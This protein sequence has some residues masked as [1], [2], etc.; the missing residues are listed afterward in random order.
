MANTI[1]FRQGVKS[2]L[3]VTGL[4]IGEPLYVTDDDM[5]YVAT[6]SS[7]ST[8]IGAEIDANPSLGTSHIKLATQG[9]I[10]DYVDSATIE[11]LDLKDSCDCAS[12]EDDL[13]C[14]SGMAFTVT[15]L[16]T[17]AL[18]DGVFS[19]KNTFRVD[20]LTSGDGT[21]Q[22]GDV[23]TY[24]GSSGTITVTAVAGDNDIT[25]D[26]SALS[27]ADNLQLTFTKPVGPGQYLTAGSNETI[28][29]DGVLLTLG[30]RVLMKDQAAAEENGI[31]EVTTLGATGSAALVLTRTD[32]FNIAAAQGNYKG[33]IQTNA[34]TMVGDGTIAAETGWA[35]SALGSSFAVGT[36]GNGDITWTQFNGTHSIT[37]GTGL[38]KVGN[39]LSV[40]DNGIGLDQMAGGTDGNLI[41]FDTSGDPAYVAT[42]TA[43][44]ILTSNGVGVAPT[45]QSPAASTDVD[46]NVTNLTAR[47]PQVTENVTIGDAVDVT[48][49]T[50]GPLTATGLVTANAG[51]TIPTTKNLTMVS[52]SDILVNTDKFT[53]AGTSGNTVIAGTAS[54]AGTATLAGAITLG[55]AGAGSALTLVDSAASTAG[56]DFS[57]KGSDVTAGGGGTAN[58]VGGDLTFEAGTSTGTGASGNIVFKTV[59]AGATAGTAA[60]D[61]SATSITISGAGSLDG[62]TI[63]GGAF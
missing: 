28:T 16:A 38:S 26:G 10:K 22:I 48:V 7:A 9:A 54:V 13:G 31:W 24:S 14:T 17:S 61:A 5:L 32:D 57:L 18:V 39:T 25:V 11:G 58:V 62:A 1:T 35:V 20:T 49:T 33:V 27:L 45:F 53:V 52:D 56:N 46:V 6:S 51:I 2:A 34:Y 42:G 8:P 36:D 23:M 44:H 30:M 50:S 47:L 40:S 60:S 19:S 12:T 37:A 3:P 21:I 4:S 55:A 63:A 59:A 43:T 29:V 15:A 41:T